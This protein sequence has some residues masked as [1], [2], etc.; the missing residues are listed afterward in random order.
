MYN[1]SK[2]DR[3]IAYLG[4][5]LFVLA[6]TLSALVFG[7][8]AGRDEFYRENK[9]FPLG[10][11]P[12]RDVAL[13]C[14]FISALYLLSALLLVQVRSLAIRIA[15]LAL[16]PLI[17]YQCVILIRST[18]TEL[19]NSV[20]EYSGPLELVLYAGHLLF[21]ALIVFALLQISLVWISRR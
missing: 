20:L 21:G 11:N 3:W 16:L 1:T 14:F 9:F 4:F 15:S 18:P 2:L 17:G 8:G 7:I 19:P 6:A 12:F 10:F 5:S 13:R